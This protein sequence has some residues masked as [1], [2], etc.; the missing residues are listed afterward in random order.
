MTLKTPLEVQCDTQI[1]DA[2]RHYLCQA[3]HAS[4]C[5]QTIQSNKS[6]MDELVRRANLFDEL[7]DSLEKARFETAKE[8]ADA[9]SILQR[10]K[11]EK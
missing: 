2:D 11:E 9:H 10:A 7:V 6:K 4:D 5:W 1:W 3:G 8:W